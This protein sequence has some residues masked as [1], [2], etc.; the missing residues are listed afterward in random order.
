MCLPPDISRITGHTEE[1]C[2]RYIK[3][4]KRVRTLY[5]SMNQNEIAR[6]LDMS[7][8]VV[9]EY[10]AIHEEFNKKEEKINDGSK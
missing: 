1:A 9:K 8:S 10:I 4:Y 6:T 5:G 3:A 2:D 7:E